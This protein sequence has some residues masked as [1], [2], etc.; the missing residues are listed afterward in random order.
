MVLLSHLHIDHTNDLPSF[1][2]YIYFS[3]TF[4]GVYGIALIN[5]YRLEIIIY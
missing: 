2:D 3:N 4:N 1:I 5:I